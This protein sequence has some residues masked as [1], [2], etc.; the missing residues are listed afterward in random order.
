MSIL[1]KLRLP[2]P[3]MMVAVAALLFALG[4]TSYAAATLAANSVGAKQLKKNAVERVKI[5]NNAVDASKVLDG[6]LT[7]RDIKES[8]LTKVPATALADSATHAGSSAAIDKVTYKAVQGSVAPG[9]VASAATAACDPGQHVI[10]GGMK[11][12]DPNNAFLVDGYPDAANTAWTGHAGNAIG[13]PIGF[14]VWAICTTATTT[15]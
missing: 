11:V 4:G 12:D 14:T 7:G 1:R 10:G 13:T 15:G 3:S 8:T 6:S 2:S 9:P 5:K